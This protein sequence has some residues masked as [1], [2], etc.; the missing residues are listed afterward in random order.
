[1]STT[2]LYFFSSF[3]CM[4][5]GAN[6]D[7]SETFRFGKYEGCVRSGINF[8]KNAKLGMLDTMTLPTRTLKSSR[9]LI[10]SSLFKEKLNLGVCGYF[11]EVKLS[12][13]F[14]TALFQQSDWMQSNEH[15]DFGGLIAC[16]GRGSSYP[17][18]RQ[19]LAT[20]FR[21]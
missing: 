4:D 18:Y 7:F 21:F 14:D 11:F 19:C 16:H 5:N 17:S 20:F 9:N 8:F 6:T 12:I 10:S 1:M 3:S 13:G 15:L 2:S